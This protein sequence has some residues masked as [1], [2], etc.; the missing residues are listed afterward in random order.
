[1]RSKE[2][3]FADDAVAA[4]LDVNVDEF[5]EEKRHIEDQ[6][7]RLYAARFFPEGSN[8]AECPVGTAT[9]EQPSEPVIKISPKDAGRTGQNQS[10]V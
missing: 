1:M 6:L 10:A 4:K 9:R 5:A 7:R 3:T 8:M 2:R